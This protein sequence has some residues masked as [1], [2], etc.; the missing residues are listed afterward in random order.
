MKIG[1]SGSL[2]T[3]AFVYACEEVEVLASAVLLSSLITLY[4]LHA[5]LEINA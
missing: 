1:T 3:Y 4:T 2:D 5:C